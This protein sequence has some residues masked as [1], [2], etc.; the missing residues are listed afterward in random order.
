M[1]LGLLTTVK[2]LPG[3][4]HSPDGKVKTLEQW[5]VGREIP[6]RFAQTRAA[7]IV[8]W[9]WKLVVRV[10]DS[11]YLALD[12]LVGGEEKEKR[13]LDR[14]G[15]EMEERD[16]GRGGIVDREMNGNLGPRQ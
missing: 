16:R 14:Q 12:G 11:V 9:T 6:N 15:A 8:E 5:E 7:K 3:Q 4:E 2:W 1:L 13:E 10:A